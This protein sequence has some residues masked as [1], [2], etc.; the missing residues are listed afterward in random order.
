LTAPSRTASE[1]EKEDALQRLEHDVDAWVATTG[2][3]RLGI[4]P[5]HDL[6]LIEGTAQT[7]LATEI[8]E[9][10]GDAFAAK[11]G[12]DPL[13]LD[14]PYTYLRIRPR[15]LQVWRKANELDGRELM[16]DGAW[17]VAD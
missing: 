7:L 12:F 5:T 9:E 13:K 15:R 14:S 3:L 17:I 8:T 4:G 6:V 10:I 11:A 1:R 16:R 2:K